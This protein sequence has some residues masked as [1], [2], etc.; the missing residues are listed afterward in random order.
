MGHGRRAE[1]IA[2]DFVNVEIE[3]HPDHRRRVV[4]LWAGRFSTCGSPRQPV[5]QLIP[6][7]GCEQ[8][9]TP[10]KKACR[11]LADAVSTVSANT[12]RY[13]LTPAGKGGFIMNTNP[14]A[15]IV[16]VHGGFVDGSGWRGV[17]DVLTQHGY[18]VTVVQN[19]T[20]SLQGDAD[21]TRRI[22]QAQDGP[23]VLVGH[24]YG[25]AVITAAAQT[26]R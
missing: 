3:R 8:P 15:S 12:S 11:G 9:P 4:V 16:L 2:L 22:V 14:A 20:L 7:P 26:S 24:S 10:G 25:G 13:V 21:A 19:P 18:Q 23:V 5:A 6:P 17:Y 1:H